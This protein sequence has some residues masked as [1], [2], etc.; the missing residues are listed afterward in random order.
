MKKVF[1]IIMSAM[2][3]VC[4]MPAMA[5]ADETPTPTPT[6]IANK[7]DAERN[8]DNEGKFKMSLESGQTTA[9]AEVYKDYSVFA[10]VKGTKVDA[11][12][13]KVSADM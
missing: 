6:F 7:D 2:M 5:F 3:L 12:S 11:S 1:A 9:T 4:F 13:V 8:W 10:K